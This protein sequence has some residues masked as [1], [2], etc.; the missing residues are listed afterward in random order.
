[1]LATTEH[2]ISVWTDLLAQSPLVC[3]AD[4]VL[5]V[6]LVRVRFAASCLRSRCKGESVKQLAEKHDRRRSTSR[7]SGSFVSGTGGRA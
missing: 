7:G 6:G 2:T 3:I 5:T 4:L 1:M